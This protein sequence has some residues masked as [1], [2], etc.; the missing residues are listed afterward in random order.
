[1][2]PWRTKDPAIPMGLR[3]GVRV[4]VGLI[5][6]AL[7]CSWPQLLAPER[8][9]DLEPGAFRRLALLGDDSVAHQMP[10]FAREVLWTVPGRM[11]MERGGLS[12]EY[13]A[14]ILTIAGS[15]LSGL[16]V[17]LLLRWMTRSPLAAFCAAAIVLV[18]PWRTTSIA[19]PAVSW[20]FGP[21]LAFLGIGWIARGGGWAAGLVA[22]GG[23]A[24]AGYT[25]F[26]QLPPVVL[27]ALILLIAHI[28]L[29]LRPF[30]SG[31]P[32]SLGRLASGV[33]VAALAGAAFL[34]PAWREGLPAAPRGAGTSLAGWL[35]ADGRMQF[36]GVESAPGGN[37]YY[38]PVLIGWL[39]CILLVWIAF[40]VR[41]PRM[42]PWWILTLAGFL[43]IQGSQLHFLGKEIPS[44]VMPHA[45]L[46]AL[47][48]F[49][50]LP[51]P[52]AW[53]PCLGV[54]LA[55]VV[56]LGLKEWQVQHGRATTFLLAAITAVELRP[57]PMP[58][59]ALQPP[60]VYAR[61]ARAA[62]GS[63]LELPLDSLNSLALWHASHTH[64]RPVLFAPLFV[65]A[66]TSAVGKVPGGLLTALAPDPL[67]DRTVGG[68]PADAALRELEGEDP[69]RIAEW[70]RW[71]V[72]DSGVR[73]IVFRHG[74][75]I[76]AGAT[77]RDRR[78]TGEKL[79][80]GLS[81]WYFNSAFPQ[82]RQ[83]GV[84]E[85]VSEYREVADRSARAH[86]LL[87]HWFG[88]PESRQGSAYAEVWQVRQDE[89]VPGN[90]SAVP[91]PSGG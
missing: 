63:V 54:A 67:F 57:A 40:N 74:P 80:T 4:F 64:G 73:W 51:G 47:P 88:R 38:W 86:A 90:R 45:W 48:G 14:L 23:A 62:E 53:L 6:L 27:G 21:A 15:F 72:E 58:E 60:S 31:T 85:L 79:K 50:A 29:M 61:M 37:H 83:Q 7:L 56:A 34:W 78:T 55:G 84:R 19:D 89:S 91:A 3:E 87:E 17:W 77:I 66:P 16:A 70:R 68:L 28:P 32:V 81:P 49:N 44:V 76:G 18:Q 59:Y 2:N 1:V 11:L 52:S 13:A 30:P 12:A 36:L 75:D 82:D 8:L 71:L 10:L 25:S 65:G 41:D 39:V 20:L 9:T 26:A 22:G 5:A 42:R 24:L 43:L 46:A 69:A 35:A 33:G